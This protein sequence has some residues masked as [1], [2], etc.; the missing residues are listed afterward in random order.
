LF[1]LL[2]LSDYTPENKQ[3]DKMTA[4]ASRRW[5]SLLKAIETS[6]G[7]VLKIW[8]CDWQHIVVTIVLLS[9]PL[10]SDGPD[11]VCPTTEPVVSTEN[12]A[13]IAG[14]VGGLVGVLLLS[15]LLVFILW[16]Q[17]CRNK[18]LEDDSSRGSAFDFSSKRVQIINPKVTAGE[19]EEE[20]IKKK[21]TTL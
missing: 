11:T 19:Q 14:V 18:D 13:I 3:K 17:F 6:V 7:L 15:L 8:N 4:I 12:T 5:I 16:Y 9:L 2:V 1:L 21:D 20:D 10:D